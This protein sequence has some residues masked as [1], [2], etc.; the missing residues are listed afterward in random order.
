MRSPILSNG[1]AYPMEQYQY[2][3]EIRRLLTS[4]SLVEDVL[5]ESRGPELWGIKRN[6]I[7]FYGM[8]LVAI[9]VLLLTRSFLL[10]VVLGALEIRP[11]PY[12]TW[13]LC[14]H[15][16]L[17]CKGRRRAAISQALKRSLAYLQFLLGDSCRDQTN[18]IVA[19]K[20]TA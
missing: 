4:N 10:Q 19:L 12:R 14:T 16:E 3:F 13:F 17:Y 18:T 11:P 6:H 1:E 5:K 9:G 8:H 15:Q 7:G 2:S 20:P